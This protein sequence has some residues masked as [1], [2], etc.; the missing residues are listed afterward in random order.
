MLLTALHPKTRP[1]ASPSPG[2]YLGAHPD[3]KPSP[4]R[5][6]FALKLAPPKRRLGLR[7]ESCPR[8][9]NQ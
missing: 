3:A 5:L 8:P 4:F 2:P 6:T 7:R 1:W 9:Q